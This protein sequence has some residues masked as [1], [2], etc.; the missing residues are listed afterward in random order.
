METLIY[1]R[2]KLSQRQLD[3][4]SLVCRGFRNSEIALV[5][6]ISDR[7]VKHCLGQLFLIFDVA[8]RTELAGTAQ[9]V[10]EP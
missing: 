3:V 6:N 2:R 8:N 7:S 4:L 1:P 10:Y 9:S 5:L